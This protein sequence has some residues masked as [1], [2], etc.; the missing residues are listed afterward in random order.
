MV[1]TEKMMVMHDI[2]LGVAY[3]MESTDLFSCNPTLLAFVQGFHTQEGTS[4][5][6]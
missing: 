3:E 4:G 2:G 6:L 5:P 1:W